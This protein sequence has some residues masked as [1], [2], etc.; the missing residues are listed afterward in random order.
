MT[1]SV[2]GDLDI[3]SDVPAG[4]VLVLTAV[5]TL[6]HRHGV[7]RLPSTDIRSIYVTI[8]S[9]TSSGF[10]RCKRSN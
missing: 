3:A 2:A 8:R 10:S 1:T 6:D 5:M 9:R 7:D 4:Q